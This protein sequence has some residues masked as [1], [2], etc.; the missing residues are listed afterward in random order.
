MNTSIT[1][2]TLFKN[3]EKEP[4]RILTRVHYILTKEDYF[5]NK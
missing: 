1:A 3:G 2:S 4:G 5:A